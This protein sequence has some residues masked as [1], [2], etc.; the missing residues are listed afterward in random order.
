MHFFEKYFNNNVKNDF[1]IK[2]NYKKLNNIPKIK[3]LILNFGCR[4]SD[5][6]K[7]SIA[8][9]ALKLITKK[10]CNFV[11][12]KK[13]NVLLKIRKG[14][15][16]GC[17]IVITKKYMFQLLF[18]LVFQVLPYS[19]Y[20]IFLKENN[21]NSITL[22]IKNILLF[23]VLEQNYI[24]FNNVKNLHLTVVTNSKTESEFFY[25]LNLLKFNLL[26]K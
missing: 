2:F 26:Q 25:F 9:L 16:V 21:K 11:S 6:K 19:K 8:L 12:S 14:E 10:E 4:S 5:L 20:K 13:S 23:N 17:K 3:K 18:R 24:L 1:I 7:L 15:P 22:N